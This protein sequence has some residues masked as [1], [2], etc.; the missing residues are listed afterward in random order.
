MEYLQFLK[1]HSLDVGSVLKY[2]M[3]N[4]GVTGRQLAQ[5]TG[6]LP[7]RICDF[8]NNRR[9]ISA[10]V[11]LQLEK[12]LDI[13]H[14]GYF[15]YIQSNN[16]IYKAARQLQHPVPDLSKIKKYIFWDSDIEKI[17][18]E[19][20]RRKVVQRIFEYGDQDAIEEIK[21][22]YGKETVVS[23]LSDMDD[24]RLLE[25]RNANRDKYLPT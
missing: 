17:N 1:Y 23:I 19:A 16:D 11:S 7:Q 21:R 15:L 13:D 22:F 24:Q 5:I 6:I 10:L 9:R 2:I 18:W 12:A 4:K 25:R 20:D 8:V 14:Q 3:T